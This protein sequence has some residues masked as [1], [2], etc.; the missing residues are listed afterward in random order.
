MGDF[1]IGSQWGAY[2]LSVGSITD[3]YNTLGANHI[4][5]T[6]RLSRS[7]GYSV[8]LGLAKIKIS[9]VLKNSENEDDVI[10]RFQIGTQFHAGIVVI[11][12]G[13]DSLAKS[14]TG[15]SKGNA[16]SVGA[17]LKKNRMTLA[18]S[19]T[20]TDAPV[21]TKNAGTSLQIDADNVSVVINNETHEAAKEKH[22]TL[23]GI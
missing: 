6:F 14:E 9:T 7:L 16:F 18:A 4:N 3:Q 12:A 21:A 5:P 19:F 23:C 22:R 8:K 15:T 13:L 1:S 2:Y 10:D 17:I 11:A 20:N